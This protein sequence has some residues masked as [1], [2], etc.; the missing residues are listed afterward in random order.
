MDV[1]AARCVGKSTSRCNS[2]CDFKQHQTR[3]DLFDQHRASPRNQPNRRRI[4]KVYPAFWSV[5]GV[6]TRRFCRNTNV[7]EASV[8]ASRR[9]GQTSIMGH[10][11]IDAS[12]SPRSSRAPYQTASG[13]FC[14]NARLSM[15]LSATV[16]DNR[17]QQKWRGTSWNPL[18]WHSRHISMIGRISNKRCG[19]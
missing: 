12:R 17:K 11:A 7:S 6:T 13:I 3:D 10:E 4:H 19:R 1:S 9:L 2:R 14:V 16:V 5:T 15:N 18:R 8:A